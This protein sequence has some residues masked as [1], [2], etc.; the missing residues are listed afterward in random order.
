VWRPRG[1]AGLDARRKVFWVDSHCHLQ[2][3]EG[4]DDVLARAV[5][6]GVERIVCVGTDRVSSEQA[7]ALAARHDGVWATVGLHPHDAS[8]HDEELE[9]LVELAS[10]P[11]VVAIGE[12]GFD[13]HYRYSPDDA[14]ET[15]FRAQVRLAHETEKPLVIH[16][17][18]AWD[19]TF[20]V[21]DDERLPARTVFHCFTG[22]AVEAA[23]AVAIGAYVSFSGIVTFRKSDD[24][25]AGAAEVPIDRLLVETD[26]PYLAPV[27]HRGRPNE[28]SY[29]P[30]VGSVLAS[31]KRM[32]VEQLAAA[33]R[34]NAFTV[35]WPAD[36]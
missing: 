7:V 5:A 14:Q 27:P 32:P 18:A 6:A 21:L 3:L 2:T 24:V 8:R 25:R 19:A 28:P 22:G 10:S 34:E 1:L 26:A 9:A 16:T 23:R 29:L 13:L 4:L 20:A 31:T 17:R 33:T 36:R 35:F 12:T 30:W 11:H 15:A